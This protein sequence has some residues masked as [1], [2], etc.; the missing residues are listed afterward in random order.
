MFGKR[1]PVCGAKVNKDIKISL[2]YGGKIYYFDC[3]A[4]KATFQEDPNRFLKKKTGIG[5]LKRL[6][7]GSKDVPKS[8][9]DIK[10]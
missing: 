6:A 8:C 3:Q 7:K 9:H 1:D 5:L 4:C 2:E 10:K